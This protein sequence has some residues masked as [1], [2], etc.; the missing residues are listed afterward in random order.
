[1]VFRIPISDEVVTISNDEVDVD[2]IFEKGTLFY[3]TINIYSINL[4]YL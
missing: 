1:M 3:A 2:F 4:L